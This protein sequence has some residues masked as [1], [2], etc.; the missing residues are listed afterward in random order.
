MAKPNYLHELLGALTKAERV[1]VSSLELKGKEQAL[2]EFFLSRLGQ[3]APTKEEIS[4]ALS[5]SGAHI[6]K[7]SSI[8]LKKSY[9]LL[10]PAGGTDL[11]VFLR[12]KRLIRHLYHELN[13]EEREL[14][15]AKD[16]KALAT[17]YFE[18]FETLHAMNFTDYD[19]D[20]GKRYMNRYFELKP[21]VT[22][23]ERLMVEGRLIRQL[24][25]NAQAIGK[26]DSSLLSLEKDLQRLELLIDD[27][28]APTSLCQFYLAV[29]HFYK[30]V[31]V[32]TKKQ[33]QY[34]QVVLDIMERDKGDFTTEDRELLKCK[35]ADT[36]Y[37]E[38]EFETAYSIYRQII[39]YHVDLFKAQFFFTS[40][41]LQLSI[42]C[43]DHENTD[44]IVAT[45]Y[46][47]YLDQGADGGQPATSA[48]LCLAKRYLLQWQPE[49]AYHYITLGFASNDKNILASFEIELRKLET[50]YFIQKNDLRFAEEL[51][52][53]HSKYL[54][55]K[56]ISLKS[57]IHGVFFK[58]L[59]AILDE[60][61]GGKKLN[62]E[63]EQQLANQSSG[64]VSI[65]GML[66]NNIR[67]RVRT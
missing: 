54:Q 60:R 39:P 25:I 23:T 34:L 16:T 15:R 14:L 38:S 51:I 12:Q 45:F 2:L 64:F 24:I 30:V 17:F 35:I 8:I 6:D 48:A 1:T 20:E 65:Y 28:V 22:A 3:L 42:I 10:V 29:T 59:R 21:N 37:Q 67:N 58:L 33:R 26:V 56:K 49:Q 9:E 61:T 40:T 27:S 36:Y 62:G 11:W 32:D 18:A 66:L 52:D 44:Q 57:N 13:L 63:Q 46:Q 4:A 50:V 31:S 55:S 7:T 53:K 47:L 41:Y 43:K 19:P 5:M